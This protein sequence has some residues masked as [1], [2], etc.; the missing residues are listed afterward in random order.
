MTPAR[1]L[2][3]DH[4]RGRRQR[5]HV[6]RAGQQV[7]GLRRVDQRARSPAPAATSSPST[8]TG[9]DASVDIG[10]EA[11]DEAAAV[12][13]KLADSSAAPA[14]PVGVQR[15]TVLGP[16]GTRPTAGS[17]ST[18]PSSS[19]TTTKRQ[20]DVG[21]TTSAGPDYPETV[22]GEEAR[23]PIGGINVGIGSLHRRAG[24]A[25]RSRAS[26]SLAGEPGA[27]TPTRRPTCRPARRRY[28]DAGPAG[29]VPGR[30][31]GA[32]PQSIDAAGPRPATP[33]WSDDR[34]RRASGKWHPPTR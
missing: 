13:E 31:A 5:W 1:D 17:R 9:A 20:P 30:P 34:Q 33:Y 16:F 18:G 29:A 26:A 19:T 14:G 8:E 27:V 11:G 6:A 10:S 24:R 23:P 25:P 22:E 32:V 28:E 15:G 2:G 4:R 7:R 21:Q 12:I 3:P